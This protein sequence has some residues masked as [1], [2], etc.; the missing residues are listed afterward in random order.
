MLKQ[1]V[2]LCLIVGSIVV[3]ANYYVEQ[4]E[5][6]CAQQCE[7]KGL[8]YLYEPPKVGTVTASGS[9]S[10]LGHASSCMCADLPFDFKSL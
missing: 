2:A 10:S 4:D 9:T 6:Q 5:V 8:S 3:V 1:I 7:N